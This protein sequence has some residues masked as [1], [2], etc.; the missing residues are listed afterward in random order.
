M[1]TFKKLFTFLILCLAILALPAYCQTAD[2]GKLVALTFKDVQAK[3]LVTTFRDRSETA[4]IPAGNG[5]AGTTAGWTNTGTNINEAL[6]PQSSTASTFTIP[7]QALNLGDTIVGYKV[8]AQIESAGGTATL[9]AD[10]RKLTNAAADP[11][12]SS[13][14]AITQVSV[15]ADTAVAASKTLA[16][17]DVVETRESFYVL[18]T[19]T[20]AASTDIRLLDIE[21]TV[22]RN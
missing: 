2:K 20:T 6:L 11:V 7:L 15:T 16:T 8:I 12:D 9:D 21:V 1:D 19:G 5:R 22:I 3:A 4:I 17:A 13:V 10:L 18:L 14:G